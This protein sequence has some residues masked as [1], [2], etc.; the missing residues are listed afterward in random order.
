MPIQVFDIHTEEWADY[1]DDGYLIW[2]PYRPKKLPKYG[3]LYYIQMD[4]VIFED[5]CEIVSIVVGAP[6]Y[7]KEPQAKNPYISLQLI[8]IDSNIGLKFPSAEFGMPLNWL[9]HSDTVIRTVEVEDLPLYVSLN[10]TDAYEA[11]MDGRPVKRSK[12]T[13]YGPS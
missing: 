9:S 12:S 5:H 13:A 11:L 8:A 6:V 10:T 3:V 1:Y 7:F 4:P 2:S